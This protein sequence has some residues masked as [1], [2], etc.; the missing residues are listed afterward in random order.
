MFFQVPP[1]L[2][3]S[4]CGL[5]KGSMPTQEVHIR[6]DSVEGLVFLIQEG[7]KRWQEG[8]I[9]RSLVQSH[10]VASFPYRGRFPLKPNRSRVLL[11]SSLLSQWSQTPGIESLPSV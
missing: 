6:K 5:N 4:T 9:V 1:K 2:S 11:E 10:G 8:R 3:K 7:V